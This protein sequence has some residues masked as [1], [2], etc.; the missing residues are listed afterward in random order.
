MATSHTWA[1]NCSPFIELL[2]TNYVPSPDELLVLKT[3]LVEHCA[4]LER[5]DKEI[6]RALREKEKIKN[7]VEA[8]RALMSPVRQLPDEVLGEIFVH[9]LPTERNAVRSLDEAP[10]LLITI[11]RDWRRVA[12]NT[13]RLW[14]SIHIFLPPDLNNQAMFRRVMG[15]RTWL[16]RSGTLP[17]SI[18][19]HTR[20][21]PVHGPFG[22][23]KTPSPDLFINN[24]KLLI[25]TITSYGHRF[26]DLF[27]SLPP[28]YL[29]LFDELSGHRSFSML[30]HFRVR[31]A[32]V[33]NGI[34]PIWNHEEENDNV[35]FAPLLAR[36][37]AL[38]RLEVSNIYVRAGG[39]LDLPINWSI[40]TDLKL[41]SSISVGLYTSEALRILQRT[42]NLQHLQ[43]YFMLSFDQHLDSTPIGRIDL[44]HLKSMRLEFWPNPVGFGESDPRAQVSSIFDSLST[45]SLKL[46][47]VTGAWNGDG[48]INMKSIH[49][50]SGIPFHQLE[51]LELAFQTTPEELTDC[52]SS[53]PELVSF[54]YKEMRTPPSFCDSHLSALTPSQENPTPLCPRLTTIRIIFGMHMLGETATVTSSNILSFVR[55]RA[56]T[57]LKRFDMFFGT[58]DPFFTED[59]LDA[60]R[61][62][63]EAGL[64]IRLHSADYPVAKLDSPF[65]GLLSE[66]EFLQPPSIPANRNQLSDM[67]GLFATRYIV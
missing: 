17:L 4:E 10:L 63:K 67:E 57:A 1:L 61:K 39:Y 8:H 6:A 20:S 3:L 21:Q 35:S 54:Q 5:L 62:L 34:S 30:Q 47:A 26:G 56:N 14:S 25:S 27:L 51:T 44:P 52:L 7:F 45:P 42:P 2:G 33:H 22:V 32:D 9:C 66:P 31:D 43:I 59:D 28:S 37:A 40:L 41:Q 55:S 65:C 29:R 49:E 64:N 36:T 18:S 23:A 12:L 48:F 38:K 13:H 50:G 53:A 60:L 16:G 24:A 58:Q 11:C 15:I 46:L 19:L